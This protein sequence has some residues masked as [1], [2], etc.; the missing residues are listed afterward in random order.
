[1][2]FPNIPGFVPVLIILALFELA[3]RGLALWLAAQ[4]KEKYWFAALLVLNTAGILPVIYLA[5]FKKQEV[6]KILSSIR[7]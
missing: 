7:A 4:G 1:M 3:V 5:F 2:E 6:K